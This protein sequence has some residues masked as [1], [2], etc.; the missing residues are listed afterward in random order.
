M[1]SS[2][3]LLLE[4]QEDSESADESKHEF[5]NGSHARN[6]PVETAEEE[7]HAQSIVQNEVQTTANLQKYYG[8]QVAFNTFVSSGAL[9]KKNGVYVASGGFSRGQS[10]CLLLYSFAKL[11]LCPC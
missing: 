2:D 9:V 8:Q 4:S 11:M 7:E 10:L 3:M 5:L 6:K 1:P